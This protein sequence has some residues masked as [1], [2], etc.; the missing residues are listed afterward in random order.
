[1]LVGIV[2]AIFVGVVFFDYIP[3]RKSRKRK[4]NIFYG[5]VLAVSFGILVLFTFE[6]ALPSPTKAIED[7]VKMVV[8]IE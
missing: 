6:V 1:M 7:L 8:P 5:T 3:G 2:I 4:E